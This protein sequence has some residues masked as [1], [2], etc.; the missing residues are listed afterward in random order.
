MTTYHPP[1]TGLEAH[2]EEEME[3]EAH[4]TEELLKQAQAQQTR[5]GGESAPSC[6]PKAEQEAEEAMHLGR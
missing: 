3:R 1:M 4:K 2:M 5:L 6:E